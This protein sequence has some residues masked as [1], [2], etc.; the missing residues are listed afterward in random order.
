MPF[1]DRDGSFAQRNFDI[2]DLQDEI[3]ADDLCGRLL[4]IFYLD[5]TQEENIPPDEAG[6]LAYGADYFLREFVIPDRREN[7]FG[8]RP[9]RVRQF[10]GNWYIVHNLE[11]N[12]AE[13]GGI[14]RGV[15]AFYSYCHKVGKVTAELTRS[16]NEECGQLDFYRRRID[17]FW[18]IEGGGDE[19][20][21]RECSLK[22]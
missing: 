8:L 20:W 10:A 21:E 16:V 2:T 7:I 4:R 17:T 3:R 13:L 6:T 1:V 18:A 11:P 19:K 14:L 22:D 9:G 15:A 12:M 5:L